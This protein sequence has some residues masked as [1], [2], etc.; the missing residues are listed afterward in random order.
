MPQIS[1]FI[2]DVAMVTSA[3]KESA[4]KRQEP[5]GQEE[6][7]KQQRLEGSS[8]GGYISN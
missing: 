3:S 2:I 5:E 4:A 8:I 6:I 1:S 7:L